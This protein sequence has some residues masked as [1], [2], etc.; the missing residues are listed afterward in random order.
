[1]TTCDGFSCGKFGSGVEFIALVLF[2]IGK[3]CQGSGHSILLMIKSISRVAR[4]DASFLC[5]VIN[6]I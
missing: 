4:T 3:V 1:M 5:P 2:A 6:M